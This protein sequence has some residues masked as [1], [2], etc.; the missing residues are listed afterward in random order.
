MGLSCYCDDFD[1]GEHDHWWEPGRTT[2][3][4][5]GEQ[6][7]ECNAPVGGIQCRTICDCEVYE[8]DEDLPPHPE[9]VLGDEPDC[10]TLS[11]HWCQLYDAMETY[12]EQR[13]TALG[14]DSDYERFERSTL[15]Y[16]CER[17][18]DLAES[19]EDLG[20]CM[21]EPGGLP[22]AHEEYVEQSGKPEILWQPDR[23][24]VL[25]PRRMSQWDFARREAK[26]RWRRAVGFVWYGGWKSWLR[27]RVWGRIK[28]RLI[29][30]VRR[31][32]GQEYKYDYDAKKYRWI[33][34]TPP[35]MR[36]VRS[37]SDKT[38]A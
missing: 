19:I 4:P 6:C 22:S 5:A 27:W 20:Y 37:A 26:R 25:H 16:R 18:S 13:E 3:A 21:I 12:R 2:V 35:W 30:P 31:Y 24:G 9:D 1:K 34:R 11:R 17:C 14:W 28:T 10:S 29:V 8:P 32:L 7:S 36:D 38:E 23:D 33:A 15:S